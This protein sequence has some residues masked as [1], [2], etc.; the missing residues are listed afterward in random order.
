MADVLCAISFEE[1][2]ISRLVIEVNLSYDRVGIYCRN[3]MKLGLVRSLYLS[4]KRTGNRR[5]HYT[6]TE[7]GINYINTYRK[8][9]GLLGEANIKYGVG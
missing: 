4:D 5:L 2:T 9:K 7:V 6:I 8:L 3:L 1:K